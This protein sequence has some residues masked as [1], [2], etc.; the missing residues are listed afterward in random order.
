MKVE[1]TKSDV[2]VVLVL[3]ALSLAANV[4]LTRRL[5][6]PRTP[7]PPALTRGAVVPQFTA[8]RLGGAEET[9]S[10]DGEKTVLYVFTPT[11]PWCKRNVPNIKRLVEAKGSEYR[12]LGISL[13]EKDLSSYVAQYELAFP[14]YA[15]LSRQT[16]EAYRL[17]GVP[18]TLVISEHG[19][20]MQNWSGAYANDQQGEVE[21]FFGVTLP[22]L[23]PAPPG[24]TAADDQS[25][26]TPR[27]GLE[28]LEQS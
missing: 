1:G 18:Q 15:N 8:T 21:K 23:A 22:G 17:G 2:T 16:R 5:V 6:Q 10:Y 26:V 11:C 25:A 4:Y 27:A 14:V 19:T 28:A 20:V 12:F 3:L 7:P 9:V 24:P 13:D